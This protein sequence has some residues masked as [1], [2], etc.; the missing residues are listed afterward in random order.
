MRVPMTWLREYVHVD[1]TTEGIAD[2][3]SI[4]TCEV[5]RIT[6]Q[7]VADEDGNL[8]RFKVGRVLLW[9]VYL[10]VAIT[11]VLLV[12]TFFLQLFGANPTAGFVQ[13]VYRSTERAMAPFRGIF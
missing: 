3:L 5:E 4:S 10:W 9:L 1:A 12:F 11:Q 7:G 6:R 8:G 2:R 13:W